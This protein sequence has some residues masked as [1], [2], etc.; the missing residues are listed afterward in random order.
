MRND[1]TKG[2]YENEVII[3]RV[4]LIF[5]PSV[6]SLFNTYTFRKSFGGIE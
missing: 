5:S 1:D 6:I 2:K 3:C 4:H